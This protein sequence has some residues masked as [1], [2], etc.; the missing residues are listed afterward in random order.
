M[1]S[2]LINFDPSSKVSGTLSDNLSLL[3]FYD[4]SIEALISLSAGLSL[5]LSSEYLCKASR[6]LFVEIIICAISCTKKM[7]IGKTM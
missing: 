4:A 7:S 2:H 6:K 1:M 5:F 3:L